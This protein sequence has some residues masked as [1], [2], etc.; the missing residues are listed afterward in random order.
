VRT[1]ALDVGNTSV[2]AALFA[3]PAER[4]EPQAAE[5]RVRAG[6]AAAERD[7]W[8]RAAR[9]LAPDRVVVGSVHRF[10]ALL[11]DGLRP[12]FGA[13]LELFERGDRFPLRADL[14]EPAQVGVDRLAAALAAFTLT[15]G[16]ALVVN[17]GTAITVDW[18]EA[19]PCFRGG[20]ILP[21][22]GLQAR[23]LR[24]W[25]DR[26]PDVAPWADAPPLHLPGRSTEEAVR[27]GLDVG[28]PGQV[29]AALADLARAAG[30]ELPVVAGGG[31][32][33]WLAARLAALEGR[34]WNARLEP[35]LVARGLALAVERTA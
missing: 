1:L 32:A 19:G 21:G 18:V 17:A 20:A 34:R 3:G 6:A 33:N 23:A 2:T 9:A 26:L 16:A 27:A 35:F 10:G 4:A 14:A 30:R 31:D 29:A 24:L 13:R 15:G 11:A 22:R 12:V 8:L 28:I 7:H 25:T 5:R